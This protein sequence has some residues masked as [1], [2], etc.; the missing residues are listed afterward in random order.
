MVYVPF[1][2]TNMLTDKNTL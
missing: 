1:D 2:S